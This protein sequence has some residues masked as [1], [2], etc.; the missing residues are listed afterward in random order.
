MKA[1][2][3][4]ESQETQTYAAMQ[5][6]NAPEGRFSASEQSQTREPHTSQRIQSSPYMVAQRKMLERCFGSAVFSLV[7]RK[8]NETGIP[9][10]VKTHMETTLNADLSD[11]RVHP[12]SSKAPEVGALAYTQGSDIHFA[13]GQFNPESSSG[14]SLLGHELTHVVQ[15]RQGRVTPTTEVGGMPVN[16]DPSL[17][18]EADAMGNKV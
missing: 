17:E 12:E 4:K 5:K 2:S 16:D 6:R 18:K 8:A 11:V 14:K 15:Q 9:D 3:E 13:P 7:Q 1:R 10:D